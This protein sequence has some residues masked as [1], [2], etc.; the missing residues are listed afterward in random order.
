[1]G[2]KVRQRKD[3]SGFWVFINHN[4]QRTQKQFSDKKTA[5]EFAKKIEARLK[6]SEANGE[7][8]VLNQPDTMTVKTYCEDW[9]STYAEVH[10]K[11][12]TAHSYRRAL[13]IHVYPVIGPRRLDQVTRAD[14]KR[15]IADLSKTGLKKQTI[16]NILT[17]LKEAYH[18]AM[19]D[20]VI[21]S[22][23]VARTGRLTRSKEDRREHVMP[24]TSSEVITLLNTADTKPYL[25]PVI[26]CAVQTGMRQG[27]LIGLKWGDI[28]FHKKFIEV[29]RGVAHGVESSTKSHKIRRVDMTVQLAKTL[30]TLKETRSLEASM[31]G[32]TM[33]EYVFV[34][35]SWTRWDDSNLRGAFRELLTKAGIRHVRFHDLRHTYASLMAEAGAPPKYVQEQLGHGSI[36]VTMDIYSHLFPGGGQE[37][38][39]KFG[40]LLQVNA[41][42]AHPASSGVGNTNT[43]MKGEVL[44]SVEEDL[45]PPIRIERT[46]HG[47]GSDSNDT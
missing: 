45:V 6:W 10:C 21:A 9:L 30:Q 35:P 40:D 43:L 31:E 26:L 34:T 3:R 28:D 1:M 2:V 46:T 41:P 11:P 15:M 38:V 36:Q 47:L 5:Q 7:P 14:I 29:R 16:H 22:N 12:S 42:Q 33:P 39:H 20:G 18:H 13:T 23:P 4:K 44:D 19:D 27:E 8:I 25:Y 37:W 17:P 32:V 24:L